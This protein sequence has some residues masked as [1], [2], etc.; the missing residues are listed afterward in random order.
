[1]A[2]RIWLSRN[3]IRETTGSWAWHMHRKK[4][5]YSGV[6][7]M[8]LHPAE[9][10]VSLVLVMS[11]QSVQNVRAFLMKQQMHQFRDPW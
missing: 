4:L 10:R 2:K 1:M 3:G 7:R 5:L 6:L 11:S 9:T 8:E